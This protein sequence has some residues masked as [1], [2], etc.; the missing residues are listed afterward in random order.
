MS[1]ERYFAIATSLE[2]APMYDGRG[3]GV[4]V[5]VCENCHKRQYTYYAD[6]G[7]TPFI[8]RCPWCGGFAQ[9]QQ[10]I[11]TEPLAFQSNIPGERI[12]AWFRPSYEQFLRLDKSLQ[13]HVLKGGL[14]FE[15]D[16]M[17]PTN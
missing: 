6:K 15:D 4:D 11:P 8:L 16:M 5:Y 1:R 17:H 13:N 7:V 2:K 3:K 9:H 10:T 12:R 14:I